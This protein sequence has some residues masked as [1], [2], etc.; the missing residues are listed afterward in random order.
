M[1]P[2]TITLHNEAQLRA[3]LNAVNDAVQAKEPTSPAA[4]KTEVKKEAAQVKEPEAKKEEP[5]AAES[6]QPAATEK[7]TEAPTAATS[8]DKVYTV[9]DAKALTMKIV[10][11]K[12]RDAAVGLLQKYGVPVAAKL[13]PEQI[14][15]F[16][17]EAE[18]LLAS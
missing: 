11:A 1:F 6:A 9:D 12:G 7:S 14:V 17:Q 10:P 15:P 13:A 4:P 18:Q 2:I 16:C 5:K 8:G 3:V